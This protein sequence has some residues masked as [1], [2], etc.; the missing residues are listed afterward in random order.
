MIRNTVGIMYASILKG[1]LR[2]LILV[3][4]CPEIHIWGVILLSCLTPN[5]G[6]LFV[7]VKQRNNLL[8]INWMTMHLCML[9]LLNSWCA[10]IY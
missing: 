1:F 6:P 5:R 10:I 7:P 3:D 9:E 8:S 2:R 4:Q